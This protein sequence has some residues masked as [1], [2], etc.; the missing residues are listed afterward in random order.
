MEILDFLNIILT[1]YTDLEY[2]SLLGTGIVSVILFLSLQI[3]AY[4]IIRVINKQKRLKIASVLTAVV[5]GG[6]VF[7]GYLIVYLFLIGIKNAEIPEYPINLIH[8]AMELA[9]L[10][11]GAIAAFL[12]LV[13][14][15]RKAGLNISDEP[16]AKIQ[17]KITSEKGLRL[18]VMLFILSFYISR[19]KSE[20][21]DQMQTGLWLSIIIIINSIFL[22]VAL[23]FAVEKLLP[24]IQ[25]YLQAN[26][27]SVLAVNFLTVVKG[28]LKII[29]LIIFLISVKP[30][31]A[32]YASLNDI[33]AKLI[34]ISISAS[35]ILIL[36]NVTDIVISKLSKFSELETNSLDKTLIEMIRMIVKIC[37]IAIFCFI[38]VR[39]LS[40]KPLTTILAGL[41]IGG[42]AV[43][44]A[45]QDTLKNFFG[46]IMIMSDRPFKVGERILVD[47]Y[48]GTIESIGFR[49]TRIRT[50][51]GNQVV[52]PND[53]V[54]QASI[55]NVGRRAS[56]RRLT[57]ITIT[58]STPP[59]KVEKALAIIRDILDNHEGM[60]QELP[61]RVYFNEFNADSLNI[62]VL[63]WYSPPDYWEYMRFSEEVNLRIMKAFAAEGIEFAFPT[64]T[65]FLEQEDGKSIKLDLGGL[66][67]SD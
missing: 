48:D 31:I 28:P 47:G 24:R 16:G 7:A 56:I 38:T 53:K 60:L 20:F 21:T 11:I 10:G 30:V 34:E 66:K 54:A 18:V 62:I 61:P 44:L 1:S 5:K 35:T 17:S 26:F 8:R 3:T 13:R 27:T 15:L 22:M 2:S 29:I 57:N 50:L 42:L 23:F 63:Y 49:S 33:A 41:G 65:T 45:A 36:F 37:F 58:Y 39:V 25:F 32:V 19:L 67:S 43:A 6:R 12:R 46:S 40:G 52:I 59:E 51:T 4:I 9:I 14:P 55:E 64:Q